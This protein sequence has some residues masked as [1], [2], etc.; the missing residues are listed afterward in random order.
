MHTSIIDKFIEKNNFIHTGCEDIECS[1]EAVYKI[2][3]NAPIMLNSRHNVERNHPTHGNY[4]LES[5][6]PLVPDPFTLEEHFF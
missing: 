1:K 6:K 5:N 3:Y 2:V 4:F